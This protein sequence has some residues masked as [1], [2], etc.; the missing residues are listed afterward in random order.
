MNEMERR[1]LEEERTSPRYARYRF[2]RGFRFSLGG[3]GPCT[4]WSGSR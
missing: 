2:L 3:G 4:G 1:V